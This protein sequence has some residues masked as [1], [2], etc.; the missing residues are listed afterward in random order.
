[1]RN[2]LNQLERT[3][4]IPF[5]LY[6]QQDSIEFLLPFL[7]CIKE[8][9]PRITKCFEG[10]LQTS[11]AGI[12]DT[13]SDYGQYMFVVIP[14]EIRK[15]RIFKKS[16]KDFVKENKMVGNNQWEHK[17]VKKLIEIPICHF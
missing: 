9:D 1:M 2:F 14:L 12:H 6:S 16:L 17:V 8:I 11:I 7:D 13:F 3:K 15:S 4:T 10:K 5:H